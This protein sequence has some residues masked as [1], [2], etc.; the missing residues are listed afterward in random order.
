MPRNSTL[1]GSL[2][3]LGWIGRY[4][5][6]VGILTV[7]MASWFYG[8]YRPLTT[9]FNSRNRSVAEKQALIERIVQLYQQSLD[10]ESAVQKLSIPPVNNTSY[11]QQSQRH[12]LTFLECLSAANL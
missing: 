1:Y 7:I 2:V 11:E 5:C 10:V 8:V 6:T 12:M 3:R 9:F 4:C